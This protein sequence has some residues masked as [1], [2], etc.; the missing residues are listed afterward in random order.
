MRHLLLL[1]ILLP[2]MALGQP[3]FASPLRCPVRITGS[4]AEI[5]PNHFHSGIDLG[6]GGK[7]GEPV[8]A[9]ADGWVSRICISPWGGGKSLYI[10]HEGGYRTVYM[11][12]NDYEG[13]AAQWVHDYQ[14]RHHVYAFDTVVPKGLIKVRKGQLIAHAGNTGSSGGPHLHYEIRYAR[15]DQTLNPLLFGLSYEDDAKPLIQEVRLYTSTGTLTVGTQPLAI[16][17]PFYAGIYAYDLPLRGSTNKNGLF[18]IE[19]YVDGHL[20]SRYAPSQFLFEETRAVNALVDYTEYRSS[21]K[22][23]I[24]TRILPSAPHPWLFSQGDGILRLSDGPHLLEYRVRDH[25]G[26]ESRRSF[27]VQCSGGALAASQPDSPA[28]VRI[29]RTGFEVSIPETCLYSGDP[30]DYSSPSAG[31]HTLAHPLPPHQAYSLRM[32]APSA[33]TRWVVLCDG[34]ALATKRQGDWLTARPRTWGTFEVREDVKAPTAT[35]QPYKGGSNVV[36]K[37]ADDLSGVDSYHCYLN[38]SWQLAEYDGRRL[39]VAAKHLKKGVP[40]KLRLVLTDAAGNQT[41][42]TFTL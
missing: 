36:I 9:P 2:F 10:D 12:L 17:G 32:K 26:N 38:G 42:L 11:H 23:F 3:D 31:R 33:S 4:F 19:L 28:S 1:L 40:N 8:Y 14:Y 30:V 5:R 37:V 25:K 34:A 15:N 20:F 39:Y 24:L 27:T 29:V 41:D 35:L 16:E 18:E 7:V 13:S 6:I 22:Y 21:R